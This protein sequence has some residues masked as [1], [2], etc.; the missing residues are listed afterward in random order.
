MDVFARAASPL[1]SARNQLALDD[2]F[3]SECHRHV[4]VQLLLGRRHENA[5]TF[6]ERCNYLWTAHDLRKMWRTDLLFTLRD[7][8]QIYGKLASGGADRMERRDERG[9][10]PF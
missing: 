5:K 4:A 6:L 2:A 10:R 9:F 3:R 1:F 7:E 8:H